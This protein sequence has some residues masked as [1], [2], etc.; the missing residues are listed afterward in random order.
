MF[1]IIFLDRDYVTNVT[2]L[3]RISHRRMLLFIGNGAGIIGYGMGRGT[4]YEPAYVNAL[5]NAKKNLIALDI[6]Y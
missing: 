6:D 2:T 3:R 5:Q 1:K 4:D